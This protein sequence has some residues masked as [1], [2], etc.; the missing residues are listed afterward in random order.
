MLNRYPWWKYAIIAL[1]VA[2]GLF[3]AFPNLYGNDPGIQVR[4]ARGLTIDSSVM[5]QA[6]EAL[7]AGGFEAKSIAMDE[8]GLKIRFQDPESQ[9]QAKE[10]LSR[11]LGKGYTIALTLLPGAPEWITSLGLAPMYLGLDLRGGVHFLLE[12]DMNSALQRAEE[13]YVADIKST[14]RGDNIRYRGVRRLPDGRVEVVLR[15]AAQ[16][17]VARKLI[18]GEMRELSLA[19]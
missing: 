14:L 5:Q 10:I 9:L 17:E 2:L 16:R 19:E 13:R 6:A 12:V 11:E 8:K 7:Q 1:V 18:G 3:Y 15:D 4:G